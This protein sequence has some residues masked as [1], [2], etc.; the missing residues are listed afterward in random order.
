M[1]I[2]RSTKKT[3]SISLTWFFKVNETLLEHLIYA[4]TLFHYRFFLTYDPFI[5]FERP[6]QIMTL[7]IN[8]SYQLNIYALKC[9]HCSSP[10]FF[11][12]GKKVLGR[13]APL[14]KTIHMSMPQ[15]IFRLHRCI[16]TQQNQP[17]DVK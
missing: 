11:H 13:F 5:L 1:R 9:T 12:S 16:S 15:T 3:F 4:L 6:H 17:L 8:I 10:G 14:L 7:T 2:T